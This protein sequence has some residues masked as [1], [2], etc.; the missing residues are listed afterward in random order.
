MGKSNAL[1]GRPT[2]VSPLWHAVNARLKVICGCRRRETF[3][4]ADL[5]AGQPRD[6][7]VRELMER[8]RCHECKARPLETEMLPPIGWG[9]W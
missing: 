4:I 6:A 7:K 3:L 9:R 1:D 2:P 8:L 5:F